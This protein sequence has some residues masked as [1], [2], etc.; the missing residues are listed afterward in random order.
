MS[1][2][3]AL[4]EMGRF[5]QKTGAG[6]YAY[7]NG[8][9]TPMPDP[10][11][12]ALATEKAAAHSIAQ[13]PDISAQEILEEARQLPPDDIDWIVESLLIK[14]KV[15]AEAEIEEAWDVEIKRRLGN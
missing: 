5:G 4:C 3:D 10:S 9:R 15:P 6:F 7:E 14:D 1:V 11:V 2:S 13:R 8:A 12:L